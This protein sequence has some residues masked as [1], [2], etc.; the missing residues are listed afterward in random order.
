VLEHLGLVTPQKPRLA[1]PTL[2][3]AETAGNTSG[4]DVDVDVDQQLLSES[5]GGDSLPNV[6]LPNVPL[7]DVS[8]TEF[9]LPDVPLPIFPLPDVSL[10]EVPLPNVLLPTARLD[11]SV[12]EE[13][14]SPGVAEQV[15]IV[16]FSLVSGSCLVRFLCS[17]QFIPGIYYY[18]RHVVFGS[19]KVYFIYGFCTGFIFIGFGLFI[20]LWDITHATFLQLLGCKEPP[21]NCVEA[22]YVS[23][24]YGDLTDKAVQAHHQL[25]SLATVYTPLRA[26]R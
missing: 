15:M 3:E 9:P 13:R 19:L 16:A 23:C 1:V 20:V 22:E 8:L 11:G 7:P 10:A 18:T 4:V 17:N 6:L 26:C 24:K 14:T 2:Q 5:A 25:S 21:C 12:G